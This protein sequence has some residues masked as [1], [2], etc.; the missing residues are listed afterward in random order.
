MIHLHF[1]IEMFSWMLPHSLVKELHCKVVRARADASGDT[2]R[3]GLFDVSD[4]VVASAS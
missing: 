1:N 4:Y 3:L 2:D